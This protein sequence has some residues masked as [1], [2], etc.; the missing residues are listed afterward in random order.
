MADKLIYI[1]ND[2]TQNYPFG[3]VNLVAETLEHSTKFPT[4]QNSIKVAKVVRPINKKT[5]LQIFWD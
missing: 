2:G 4:Y 5:S 3:S 1:P